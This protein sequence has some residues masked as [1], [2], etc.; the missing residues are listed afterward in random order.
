MGA[1]TRDESTADQQRAAMLKI[2]REITA[3]T[4]RVIET[5]GRFRFLVRVTSSRI[6]ADIS[7]AEDFNALKRLFSP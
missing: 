1:L 5:V 7:V 4:P 2:V 6:V 3:D